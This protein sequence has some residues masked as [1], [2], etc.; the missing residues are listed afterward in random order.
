MKTDNDIP[1]SG[2]G[3]DFAY[4]PGCGRRIQPASTPNPLHCTRCGFTLYRN[5]A[6]AVCALISSNGKLLATVRR[7]PPAAGSLDLPG[8]FVD[9]NESAEQALAR[10]LEEELGLKVTRCSYFASHPNLYPCLG[11]TYRTLDLAFICEVDSYRTIHCA[12]DVTDIRWIDPSS[13]DL[14]LFGLES[15]RWFVKRFAAGRT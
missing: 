8:G 4:C 10:E 1:V 3:F 11:I 13:S 14:S 5:V 6:A 2:F 9:P 7:N 12:D 15:I